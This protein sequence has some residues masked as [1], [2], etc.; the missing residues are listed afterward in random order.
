M[1]PFPPKLL[2]IPPTYVDP[3][4]G[5]Y[6][7]ARLQHY[8][9][10]RHTTLEEATVYPMHVDAELGMPIDPCLLGV[11]DEDKAVAR[12]KPQKLDEKDEFLL[13]LPSSSNPA[14]AKSE[15]GTPAAN[16]SGSNTPGA[17]PQNGPPA[18][19]S[20][21]HPA[22]GRATSTSLKQKFDHSKEGQLQAIEESFRFFA[23]YDES[24]NGEEDLL[25]GLKH[26]SN[27]R[28][29][30]VEAIPL[31]P[32][33]DIWP[34]MY[35]VFSLDTCPDPVYV[36]QRSSDLDAAETKRL[37]DEARQ[38]LIFRPRVRRNNF[39][40][41]ERWIEC[42]LPEDE[43]TARRV[44][45]RLENTTQAGGDD[46]EVEFRFERSRE[47]DAPI[48]P[49]SSNRQD[50]H[51]ITMK[52]AADGQPVAAY[53]PIKNRLMAK[54]RQLPFAIRQQEE[55]DD[56]LRVTSVAL[57]LRELSEDE[58]QERSE[59]MN[60]LHER[61]REEI[62]HG[63]TA[64]T[65]DDTDENVDIGDDLFASDNEGPAANHEHD[66]SRHR[67]PSYSPTS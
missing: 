31:L 62:V 6:S 54:R 23:R 35:T 32:D 66:R 16:A 17:Q 64:R 4:A 14:A 27:S 11:F 25:R 8:V 37:G 59:A 9:E 29:R 55:L 58:V 15:A 20:T 18:T 13:H 44:R 22:S 42:F 2:P 19:Q 49:E 45:R 36:S 67:S 53:V 21:R 5:S 50:L 39:D 46:E 7:Q 28:L 52:S 51:M 43:D 65:S 61:I 3:S 63:N 34:N 10:Y 47:Y 26:P 41:D 40:E 60:T 24:P 33:E 38:T 56:P 12:P 1:V 48:R 30:A 57:Q